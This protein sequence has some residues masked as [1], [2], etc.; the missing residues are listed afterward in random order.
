MT[1]LLEA[2]GL[3]LSF[4]RLEAVRDLDFSLAPGERHGLIGPNGAG[5]T[6][7]IN[8]LA[9]A[10]RPDRGTVVLD[11]HD[12]TACPVDQRTRQ[13]LVRTFQVN[14]LFPELTALSSLVLAISE[15]ERLAGQ[16]WSALRCKKHLFDEAAYWLD[17]FGLL[18]DA[19]LHVARLPYG[20]QR[21]LE[22]AVALACRPRV[23]LLDEPAAG[24]PA[25]EGR[26]MLDVI[27]SLPDDMAVLLIE[28]DMDLVF[29]FAQ[30][31]SVLTDGQI[32]AR[33]T[34]GQIAADE[35]VR[36]VY[37]GDGAGLKG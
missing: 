19:D 22:I 1:A 16:W 30:T 23:L 12:V 35:Q 33:G 6:T 9:G 32:V 8:L 4:G 3:S 36:E 28:H 2:R 10:L 37:L 27:L 11:G 13:G 7:L 5:K 21:L 15:R 18:A 31:I 14:S 34:P 20:Q 24:L 17:R 29:G 25:S 26:A